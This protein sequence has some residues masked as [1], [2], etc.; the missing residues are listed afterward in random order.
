LSGIIYYAR[1][2]LGPRIARFQGG[3]RTPPERLAAIAPPTDERAIERVS[4]KL[5]DAVP[6]QETLQAKAQEFFVSSFRQAN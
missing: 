6:F 1:E 5:F 3:S 4:R 2:C